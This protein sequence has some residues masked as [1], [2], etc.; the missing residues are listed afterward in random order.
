MSEETQPSEQGYLPLLTE[1]FGESVSEAEWAGMEGRLTVSRGRLAE[2]L[3]FARDELDLRHPADLTAT[4]TGE[5]FV[6]IYRL[7]SIAKGYSMLLHCPLP[8]ENP[9]VP[10]GVSLWPGLDWHEREVYDMFGIHFDGHPDLRRILLPDD[11]EGHPFRK[12][13]VSVPSG[14]PLHGP[15]PVD[16]V[17]WKP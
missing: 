10:S 12:D 1:R 5:E 3:A 16:E 9:A 17:G 2:L 7:V 11:W 13:Y 15:Q 4:D 14:D 6:L 8:R